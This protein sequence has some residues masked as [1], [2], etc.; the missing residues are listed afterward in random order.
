MS[1]GILYH[2]HIFVLCKPQVMS[3]NLSQIINLLK[4]KICV[5][6]NNT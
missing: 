2:L 6:R 5:V 1:M 4:S 3:F